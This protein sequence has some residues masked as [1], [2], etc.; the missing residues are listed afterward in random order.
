MSEEPTPCGESP[1]SPCLTDVR[2]SDV[3]SSDRTEVRRA[4]SRD[5]R[6]V[7]VKRYVRSHHRANDSLARDIATREVRLLQ[8]IEQA[9]SFAGE[10]AA[11]RLVEHDCDQGWLTFEEAP[12]QPLLKSLASFRRLPPEGIARGLIA[13]GR[14]LRAIQNVPFDQ[15]DV[16][17][18][19]PAHDPLDLREYCEIRWDWIQSWTS[20]FRNSDLPQR[21][22]DRLFNLLAIWRP[23]ALV[24]AHGDYCP[25]NV[26]WDGTTLTAIDYE[27]ARPRSP[28][29]DATYFLVTMQ[30]M[31]INSPWKRFPIDEWRHHF[32][33]GLGVSELPNTPETRLCTM[34]HLLCKLGSSC[35]PRDRRLRDR[36]WVHYFRR[37]VI[38]LI[39]EELARPIDGIKDDDF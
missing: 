25:A 36:I 2:E 9:G 17:P 14:W 15:R 10:I 12:G 35:R 27:N 38:G 29:I 23:Q 5:G 20:H 32:L 21:F 24:W 26:L 13:S 3:V 6:K 18:I 11:M 8:L 22:L 33:H 34:K 16:P 30:S 7:L 31:A 1:T 19:D 28:W 39:E 37:R 4:L